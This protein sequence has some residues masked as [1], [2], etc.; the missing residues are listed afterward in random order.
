[1]LTRSIPDMRAADSV[2]MLNTISSEASR[3]K[4]PRDKRATPS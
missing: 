4:T 2:R 3:K 1:M